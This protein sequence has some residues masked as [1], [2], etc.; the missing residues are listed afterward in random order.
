MAH[1][2]GM[3]AEGG[4][5]APRASKQSVRKPGESETREHEIKLRVSGDQLGLGV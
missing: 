2:N 1:S 5:A 3:F 4:I